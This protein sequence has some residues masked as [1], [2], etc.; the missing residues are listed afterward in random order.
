MYGAQDGLNGRS[1]VMPI[2]AQIAAQPIVAVDPYLVQTLQTVAGRRL[3]VETTRGAVSGTLVDCKPDHAILRSA[4]GAMFLVR[5]AHIVWVM[6][7][8]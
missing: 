7:E 4:G 3:V 1:H 6:P 8:A 2:P 5:I